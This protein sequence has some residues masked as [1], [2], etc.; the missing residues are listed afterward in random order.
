MRPSIPRS[1]GLPTATLPTGRTVTVITGTEF[2]LSIVEAHRGRNGNGNGFK[3]DSRAQQELKT[4]EQQIAR[5][6]AAA[7][8]EDEDTRKEIQRLNPRIDALKNQVAPRSV[9]WEKT[10][11]ARHPQRPYTLDYIERVFT[12][13]SEIHGDRG[14]ADDPA[15]ICGMA[16]FHGEE[17]MI[18]GHQ[19]A[20]ATKQKVLRNFCL[21]HPGGSHNAL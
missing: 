9:A 21:P 8:S 12:D 17:V 19:K 14:F 7:S 11:L 4:I 6:Q 13:W 5:L 16:R 2:L 15:I 1:P 18:I 20:R 10:E 3:V